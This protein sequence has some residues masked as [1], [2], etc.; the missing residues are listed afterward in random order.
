MVYVLGCYYDAILGLRGLVNFL[1][2]NLH[3]QYIINDLYGSPQLNSD[4]KS[5]D[6]A[7]ALSDIGISDCEAAGKFLMCYFRAIVAWNH[8]YAWLDAWLNSSKIFRSQKGILFL[9]IVK[10]WVPSQENQAATST[11]A[12]LDEFIKTYNADLA[13]QESLKNLEKI[14]DKKLMGTV[15]AEA[16]LMALIKESSNPATS[17]PSSFVDILKDASRISVAK[18][19]CWLCKELS[20]AMRQNG[21]TLSLPA[22]S[23]LDFSWAP[24]GIVT[25]LVTRAGCG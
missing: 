23:G 25:G 8:A 16:T 6:R 10:I 24:L 5:D 11:R 15:H 21:Q 14:G 9:H 12:L 2:N 4:S 1:Q 20:E 3:E 17:L 18:K 13:I 22:T 7:E 19:C